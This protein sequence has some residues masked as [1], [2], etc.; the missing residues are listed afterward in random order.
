MSN[1]ITE[2]VG[3]KLAC[4]NV[5]SSTHAL[6]SKLFSFDAVDKEKCSAYLSEVTTEEVSLNFNVCGFLEMIV[7]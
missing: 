7:L 3:L 4:G 1:I 6:L 5:L 2:Q